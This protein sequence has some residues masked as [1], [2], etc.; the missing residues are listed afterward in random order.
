[1]SIRVT[2]RA[3]AC[4]FFRLVIA[5]HVAIV[6]DTA[7]TPGS[8]RAG[9]RDAGPAPLCAAPPFLPYA[10]SVVAEAISSRVVFPA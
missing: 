4:A 5:G 1:M 3:R 8:A 2:G 10:S 6:A 9:V 7:G